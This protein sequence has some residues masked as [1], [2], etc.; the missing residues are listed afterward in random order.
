MR[1][2]CG[3]GGFGKR[4]AG[5]RRAKAHGRSDLRRYSLASFMNE[6]SF[7]NRLD[8][9]PAFQNAM[10]R[11]FAARFAW[12]VSGWLLD[13]PAIARDS[14]R[15]GICAKASSHETLAQKREIAPP[16]RNPAPPRL[17]GWTAASQRPVRAAG[18]AFTTASD[19][20]R[21]SWFAGGRLWFSTKTKTRSPV[22]RVS[23]DSTR[24]LRA[25][26]RYS[27]RSRRR[28]SQHPVLCGCHRGANV[29]SFGA[30]SRST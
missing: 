26:A 22:K 29:M 8:P 9:S 3:S 6:R 27:K 12:L 30:S 18:A 5:R 7:V 19:A 28:A 10:C 17:R 15:Y 11:V 23:G 13:S 21:A 14:P 20:N 4:L 16:T 1:R 25:P 24:S 2:P